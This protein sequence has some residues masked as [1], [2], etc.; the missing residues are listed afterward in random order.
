[1][2]W[3]VEVLLEDPQGHAHAARGDAHDVQFLGVFAEARAVLV[4]EHARQM[5]AQR[6]GGRLDHGVG[7][8]DAGALLLVVGGLAGLGEHLDGLR[9]EALRG[10]PLGLRP[11]AL[12]RCRC[13]RRGTAPA[14][15]AR[16]G[17][18]GRPAAPASTLREALVEGQQRRRATGARVPATGVRLMERALG[19]RQ[20]TAVAAGLHHLEGARELGAGLGRQAGLGPQGGREPLQIVVVALAAQLQLGL[21]PAACAPAGRHGDVVEAELGDFA[22][23]VDDAPRQPL[24]LEEQ[25]RL[26]RRALRDALDARRA[27]RP[28]ATRPAARRRRPAPRAPRD[29]ARRRRR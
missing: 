29:A 1:M 26:Q 8:Q 21:E 27:A 2:A 23:A 11:R 24:L 3:P 18:R 12:R 16:G 9:D 17:S 10:A 20:Q 4:L 25:E 7:G 14:S 15:S 5:E 19:R 22:G 6:L 28:P 13:P